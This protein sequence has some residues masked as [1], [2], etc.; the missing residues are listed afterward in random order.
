MLDLVSMPRRG[1][2]L[3]NVATIAGEMIEEDALDLQALAV[4][5]EQY[6]AA[7]VQRTGFLLEHVAGIVDVDV[8][9]DALHAV[10]ERRA[11]RVRL[12]PSGPV[13]PLDER[14]NVVVNTPIE[15]DL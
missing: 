8:S 14:W 11:T 12:R 3:S 7:V 15:P 1:A 6:P 4:V 9:L 13:G 10:A 2:G 5:A